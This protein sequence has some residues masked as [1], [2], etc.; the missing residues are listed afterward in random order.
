[1]INIFF[2]FL[3]TEGY[4][5]HVIIEQTTNGKKMQKKKQMRKLIINCFRL[6][7]AKC[8]RNPIT[9]SIHLLYDNNYHDN[10]NFVQIIIQDKNEKLAITS[11]LWLAKITISVLNVVLHIYRSIWYIPVIWCVY[12]YIYIYIYICI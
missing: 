5:R 8:G 11:I 12:I 3:T 9:F 1:M 7:S 4:Y 2:P 10:L 6:L